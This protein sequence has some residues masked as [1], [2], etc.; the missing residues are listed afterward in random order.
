MSKAI[1]K[2]TIKDEA[3]QLQFERFCD[4][5]MI[6]YRKYPKPITWAYSIFSSLTE[7]DIKKMSEFGYLED[8]PKVELS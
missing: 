8:M 5:M 3:K 2:I 1:Y 6:A 7:L 4:N